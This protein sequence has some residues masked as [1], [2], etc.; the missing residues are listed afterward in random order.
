MESNSVNK[1]KEIG[2]GVWEEKMFKEIA[3]RRTTLKAPLEHVVLR[4]AKKKWFFVKIYFC[5]VKLLLTNLK[6]SHLVQS[7]TPFCFKTRAWHASAN[8]W[9]F[10]HDN[11]NNNADDAKA[12]AVPLIFSKN[13][14]AK[15]VKRFKP[16]LHNGTFWQPWEKNIVK[17]SGKRRKY[18]KMFSNFSTMFSTL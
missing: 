17:D 13:S 1:S 18:R 9:L 2:P 4:S 8:D 11:D 10:L 14:R 6:F 7:G 3:W 12:I 5:H 15:N 16:L